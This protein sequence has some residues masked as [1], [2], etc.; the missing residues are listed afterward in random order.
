M[1]GRGENPSEQDGTEPKTK[2]KTEPKMKKKQVR[3]WIHVELDGAR[4]LCAAAW[5]SAHLAAARH[6]RPLPHALEVDGAAA[7]RE[8]KFDVGVGSRNITPLRTVQLSEFTNEGQSR[9][10]DRSEVSGCGR[11]GAGDGSGRGVHVGH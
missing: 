2:N 6:R 10:V 9:L 11:G 4:K 1:G 5:A 7:G 3:G 8:K